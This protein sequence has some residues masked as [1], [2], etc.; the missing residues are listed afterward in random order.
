MADSI[1]TKEG[2]IVTR[3]NSIVVIDDTS[4]E[5]C[6]CCGYGECEFGCCND[7]GLWV[8]AEGEDFEYLKTYDAYT[9]VSV[10]TDTFTHHG[11]DTSFDLY[12]EMTRTYDMTVFDGTYAWTDNPNG[13]DVTNTEDPRD[14]N[15]K[16]LIQYFNPRIVNVPFT[17]TRN[18]WDGGVLVLSDS[19]SG[20][21]V[22]SLSLEPLTFN[23]DGSDRTGPSWEMGDKV[24]LYITFSTPHSAW[25]AGWGKHSYAFSSAFPQHLN[26]NA[27]V[28]AG[29]CNLGPASGGVGGTQLSMYISGCNTL[30][31]PN[32]ESIK[33]T[34][35]NYV[36]GYPPYFF[37]TTAFSVFGAEA[38]INLI[39]RPE[40]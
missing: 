26:Y 40:P 23:P 19:L 24:R 5:E 3:D 13:T 18:I 15:N 28:V 11:E 30:Q 10:G 38:T 36:S 35:C 34:G 33:F 37:G 8:C 12:T 27:G 25:L 14:C 16:G 20:F 32:P 17:F 6:V 21:C 2:R 39:E 22:G 7:Y 31:K 9:E 29:S 4:V 1:L